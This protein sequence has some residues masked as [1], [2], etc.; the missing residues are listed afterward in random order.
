MTDN[1]NRGMLLPEHHGHLTW[2]V[3]CVAYVPGRQRNS[4]VPGVPDGVGWSDAESL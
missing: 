1:E 3:V 2:A 4:S